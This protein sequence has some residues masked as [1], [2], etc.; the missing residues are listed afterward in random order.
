MALAIALGPR[1]ASPERLRRLA[2]EL[3]RPGLRPGWAPRFPIATPRVVAAVA[4]LGAGGSSSDVAV[5]VVVH[6][7]AAASGDVG[8]ELVREMVRHGDTGS[9]EALEGSYVI[10]AVDEARD[11]VRVWTDPAATRPCFMARTSDAVLIATSLKCFQDI[12]GVDRMLSP[13]SLAAMAMN[14]ALLDEYTYYRGVTIVGPARRISI[15]NGELRAERYW[16][17]RFDDSAEAVAPSAEQVADVVTD[18]VRRHLAAWKRPILALSG[19]LDSR[20][21]LAACQRLGVWIPTVTWGFDHQE[22]I[23]SDFQVGRAVAELAGVPHRS[24]WMDVDRLPAEAE[25]IIRLTDGLTGHLGNY[26]EGDR[27]ARELAVEHDAIIRGDEMFGW[28]ASVTSRQQALRRVGVNV[29]KRLALLRFLLRR[30]AADH[31]L[32][33]YAAQRAT[34]LESLDPA[35]CADDVKDVL[36]WRTRFPRLIASQSPVFREHLEVVS[37][38]IDRSV[39]DLVRGCS[40]AQRENKRY[41][42]DCARASFPEQF[43]IPLNEVHSRASWR[44]RLRTLGPAQRFLVEALLA[45]QRTFDEWFDRTAIRA[46]LG[47]MTAEGRRAA[48]P[49]GRSWL[50]RRAADVRAFLLRPAFKER[51]LLNLVTLKLWMQSVE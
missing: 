5:G 41:I 9:V 1:P 20:L 2:G 44:E 10:A 32:D 40:P 19:G 4:G 50:A 7:Y 45:P 39:I 3:L 48:W 28:A 42:A 14:G 17:R 25:R 16:Q 46:W 6:G 22:T 51:V 18:A 27:V 49:A 23:G 21:V 37:P 43:A 29:G 8:N 26:T 31:V 35:R 12:E 11:S 24:R 34:L 15:D 30:D 13:G 36:Y 47:Q 38:L 33:D